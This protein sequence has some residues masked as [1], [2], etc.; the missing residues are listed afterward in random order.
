M[1]EQYNLHAFDPQRAILKI[2]QK[3]CWKLIDR[4]AYIP[5]L[6]KEKKMNS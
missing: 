1:K 5:L 4:Q 6:L 3:I 2:V